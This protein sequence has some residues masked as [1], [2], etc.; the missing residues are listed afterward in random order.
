[1]LAGARRAELL[2]ATRKGEPLDTETGLTVSEVRERNHTNWCVHA[3]AHAARKWPTAAAKHRASIAKSLTTAMNGDLS[4]GEGPPGG[5][6]LAPGAL[7]MGIQ[8]GRP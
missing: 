8:R 4:R 6:P 3:R 7:P 2:T 1:M 5:R